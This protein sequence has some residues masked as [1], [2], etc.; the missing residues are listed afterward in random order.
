MQLSLAAAASSQPGP[1]GLDADWRERARLEL[2]RVWGYSA[3]RP[4]QEDAIGQI[5]DR[6]DSVVILPTGGGKSLCYQ[7]PA[8]L[9]EGTA[10]VFS[11]LISLMKDQVDTLDSMGIAVG[12]LNSAMPESERGETVRRYRRGELKLLYCAPERLDADSFRELMEERP[13]SCFIIDEAHCISEWGHDFRPAYRGLGRLRKQFPEISIHAFTATATEAVRADVARALGL[14]DPHWLVGE[15]ERDNLHY[16]VRY[17]QNLLK[18]VLEIVEKY[19]GEGGIVY[20]ISRK[21]VDELAKSLKEKGISALPYHAGLSDEKRQK[22]Q[23]KFV[24]EKVQVMV[25]TVAF[26][27]GIDR[28]NVRYVIHAGMPKTV[29]NYQQEAGR[30]GRDGLTSECV[31]LFSDADVAKWLR[32]MGDARTETEKILL[33]K[34]K[35][36]AGF[37]QQPLCRQRFLVEYFGQAYAPGKCGSCDYC[38]GE[39]PK[40]D[41]SVMTARK[42]LSGVAR[43][44]ERF[45]A[46]HV[47]QVLHGADTE[48]VRQFGHH[49]QSTWGLMKDVPAPTLVQFVNQL[50]HAGYLIREPEHS[51]LRLSEAGHLLM[52]DGEGEIQ[53]YQPLIPPKETREARASRKKKGGA[54]SSGPVTEYDRSLFETLRTLRRTIAEEQNVP[55]FIIFSD[56]TL[57]HMAANSPRTMGTFRL[58][59]GVGEAKLEAYGRRFIDAIITYGEGGHSAP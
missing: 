48:R 9:M 37:C 26:G 7:L 16:A 21:D 8:I 55:P 58:I 4:L 11:P 41:D 50:V 17:R 13:P 30:A 53:L 2:A 23:E 59:S 42:I 31:V 40:V 34:M 57:R 45:G 18:Q 10:I 36:M 46:S 25:A 56:A 43:V 20:C 39:Y 38:K 47:A 54:A 49:L 12:C 32:I 35:E 14:R 52:R 51:T 5:L 33:Q 19:P 1:E 15:F 6:R 27:M 24:M 3:F 29:E 44:K 28:S 22:H